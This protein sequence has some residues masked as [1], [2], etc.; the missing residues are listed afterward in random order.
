[1]T[2]R[3]ECKVVPLRQLLKRAGVE[4]TQWILDQ[5]RCVYDSDTE[6]F[7]RSKAIEME[8]RDLSRTYVAFSKKNKHI[9]GYVTL[10]IK[11]T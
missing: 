7:L 5:Y 6:S 1:M 2:M 10:A 4:K 9:Y 11:S 8:L 3:N